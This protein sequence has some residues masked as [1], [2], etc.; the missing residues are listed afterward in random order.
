MLL[1]LQIP[2]SKSSIFFAGY[3]Y[4]D[5]CERLISEGCLTE[6]RPSNLLWLEKVTWNEAY[7]PFTL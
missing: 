6:V 1:I 2:A 3:L 7:D 5:L 4:Y